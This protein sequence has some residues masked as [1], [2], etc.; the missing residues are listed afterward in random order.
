[1]INEPGMIGEWLMVGID[2]RLES[3]K[4]NIAQIS[5]E[6][7]MRVV[8]GG[9]LL[10]DIRDPDEWESG[11]PVGS[12]RIS[13]GFLELRIS[14]HAPDPAMPIA[15]ICAGGTR[16]LLGAADLLA[17][18]Y[19][20]VSSVLG[21]VSAW[22]AAGGELELPSG[23][24][25]LC[26]AERQRYARHIVLPEIGE[27]GQLRLRNAHVVI[28]GAGGLGCPAAT[29][30][31]AAG[32]GKITIIDDDVVEISNLHRQ[33]LHTESRV[34]VAKVDSARIALST[35]N[36]F[37]KITA[38]RTRV[39]AGNA[40]SLLAGADVVVDG[41]DNLATRYVLD[42]VCHE[43]GI[44][45]VHGAIYRFEGQVSVFGGSRLDG[46]ASQPCYQCLFPKPPPAELAPNCA[47][48]GV[49]GV[50][51]G[52]VGSLQGM[53]AIKLLLGIG[54]SLHG[55]LLVYDGLEASFREIKIL[56]NDKC[57]N[58]GKK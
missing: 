12:E 19:Q 7:A 9:G 36:P 30:L 26:Q 39:T 42:S 41:C 35:I 15:L 18:G 51:P 8:R 21:G 32:V 48:A 14:Q 38:M 43:L 22:K 58:C 27:A 2:D 31:A 40:K 49:L 56:K 54:R 55:R 29:Y 44:P 16:S 28:V 3:L 46:E 45:N 10:I 50:L 33:T 57:S 5:P 53:E 11:S 25:G 20:R 4:K 1:M 13:R 52:I 24:E 37:V 34:G 17:A 6:E 47:A 23:G